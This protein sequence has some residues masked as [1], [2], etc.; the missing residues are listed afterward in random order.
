[1]KNIFQKIIDGELP[2]TKIFEN[3]RILVIKDIYPVAPVHL[4]IIS[5]KP[6][7]GLQKATTV[8]LA[9]IG[10]MVSV[11]QKLAVDFGIA[12]GYRLITNNGTSAGQSVF[13]LHF[14]LIGGKQ[15]GA[16]G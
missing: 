1:M 9:L 11:A 12:D 13:Q 8:D 4:L 7:P 10:E 3:D 16:L 15:L 6:I 14:H 2:A 5:K